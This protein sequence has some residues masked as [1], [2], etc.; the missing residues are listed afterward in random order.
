MPEKHVASSRAQ[1]RHK[2]IEYRPIIRKLRRAGLLPIRGQGCGCDAGV[3]QRRWGCSARAARS[4]G[5]L[6]RLPPDAGKAAM[7]VPEALSPGS[8][9]TQRQGKAATQEYAKGAGKGLKPR[10]GFKG[11]AKCLTS[12]LE[13][14]K[15]RRGKPASCREE[16]EG[17][18]AVQE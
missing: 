4:R 2:E 3:G 15:K 10:G 6:P 16:E 18:A 17:K 13:A 7:H 12:L 1:A 8:R 14:H 11:G 9:L 5:S